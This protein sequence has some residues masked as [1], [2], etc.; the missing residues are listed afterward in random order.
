[1]KLAIYSGAL[2][3]PLI[4]M[5]LL[6]QVRREYQFLGRLSVATA[7]LV[8]LLYFAH[9]SLTCWSALLGLW[10]VP[11][12]PWLA[13]AC[14]GLVFIAGVILCAAGV[15]A[16]GSLQQMS[17][18][19]TVRLFADGIY[20][21]SRN[22]QNVG[23]GLALFG[24]ALMGRSGLA[25]LMSVFF[26]VVFRIYLPIEESY[27]RRIFGEEYERYSTH[28]SRYFGPPRVSPSERE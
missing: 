8:W 6:G 11:M 16:F 25:L 27:L 14:G 19:M 1:M 2:A 20:R 3:L 10:P 26:C 15:T 21:W 5:A 7:S 24:V 13:L 23:L 17:G 9:V 12:P 4:A 28:T 22:P 18:T